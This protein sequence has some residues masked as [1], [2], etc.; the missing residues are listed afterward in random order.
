MA[1]ETLQLSADDQELLEQVRH[2]GAATAIELAVK[3]LR[4]P[5]EVRPKLEWLHQAGLLKVRRRNKG[6]ERNIYLLTP[7]GKQYVALTGLG[8]RSVPVR[9]VDE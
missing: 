1:E 5:D 7:E 8:N 2:L 9:Y 3:T 6:Y 4:Q